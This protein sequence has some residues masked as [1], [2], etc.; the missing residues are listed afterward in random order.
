MANKQRIER[1][2]Q[3]YQR[4]NDRFYIVTGAN[5]GLGFS[6]TKHLLYL[7]ASVI[8]ACRHRKKAEAAK[9]RLLAS[10]PEAQLFILVYDQADFT[11]IDEFVDQVKQHYSHFSGIIFNAGIYHPRRGMKTKQGFPLTMGVNY[12]GVFYLLRLLIEKGLLDKT[13][14]RRL[15]FVGSL[16]WYRVKVSDSQ[17]ILTSEQGRMM[18]QYCRSKTA[19][20]AL[21]Y[22]LSRHQTQSHLYVPHNIG[23]YTMHPGTTGTNIVG[24][25]SSSYPQWFARLADIALALFVHGPDVAS[26]GIIKALLDPS[27]SEDHVIVPRGLFHI[28]GY[29]MTK[30]YPHNLRQNGQTLIEKTSA[31]LA[32]FDHSELV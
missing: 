28:S 7:G 5:S 14:S 10:F 16:S 3:Q 27:I 20:G 13:H 11:S 9:T 2:L 22:Q 19:L 1:Y 31:V 8:M 4:L 23:V 26:L 21:A 29:P 17:A 32:T 24:N 18:S 30:R 12:L 15:I 6:V 25:S